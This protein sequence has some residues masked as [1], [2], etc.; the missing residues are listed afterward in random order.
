MSNKG[1]PFILI[2]S[3][4]VLAIVAMVS[5]V[6]CIHAYDYSYLKV[7]IICSALS[8]ILDIIARDRSGIQLAPRVFVDS[9]V[10]M[11]SMVD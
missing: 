10:S 11:L 5:F 4:C 9:A 7:T 8:V 1:P 6:S 2:S 3:V